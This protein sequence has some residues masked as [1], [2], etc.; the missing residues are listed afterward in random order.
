MRTAIEGRYELVTSPSILAEFARVFVQKHGADDA[1]VR[2][3]VVQIGTLG[4]L[5]SPSRR[6]TV[7]RDD[8]DNR[9]L[10]CAV[11]GEADLI[12]S[13]ERH[14]LELG[15]HEGIEIVT[16]SEAMRRLGMGEGD[17]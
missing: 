10:E 8:P 7:L 5:V 13:G 12:V 1:H 15:S 16:V 4:E 6:L 11:E 14:L 3:V 9:I 2:R 17:A